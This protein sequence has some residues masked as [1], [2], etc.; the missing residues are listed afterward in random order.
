MFPARCQPSF[1]SNSRAYGTAAGF[2]SSGPSATSIQGE[3]PC[4][5]NLSTRAGGPILESA[6]VVAFLVAVLM[7]DPSSVRAPARHRVPLSSLALV[8]LEQSIA[9]ESSPTS[10]IGS[11][12]YRIGSVR[13][14][15]KRPQRNP[16]GL[17]PLRQ[18]RAGMV[19][20]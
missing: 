9:T 7:G 11:P 12:T 2:L 6:A 8:V 13:I 20:R 3:P 5:G 4:R 15:E 1:F 17:V 10:A 19:L 16:L 18:A 14:L